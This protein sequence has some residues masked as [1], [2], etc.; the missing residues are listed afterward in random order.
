MIRLP[1]EIIGRA[2]SDAGFRKSLFA[3]PRA[4]LE[5]AGLKADDEVVVAIRKLDET[6]VE[7]FI[8]G[9]GDAVGDRA[10]G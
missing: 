5:K 10:A 1:P 7:E 2:M 6:A 3:D 9:L 8:A 4:T